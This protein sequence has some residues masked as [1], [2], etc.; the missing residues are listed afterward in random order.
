MNPFSDQTAKQVRHLRERNLIR[1][2]TA[3]LA[4]CNPPAP[5]G[6]GDDAAV[7]QTNQENLVITKDSLVFMKHFDEKA[8]PELV[9]A[10]L[11]KRNMSDLAAMGATPSHGVIA[12]LL[13]PTTSVKWLKK[14]YS[15]LNTTANKHAIS[16]VGGD[17]SS[18][19]E[20]LAFTLT[21]L[22]PGAAKA[23]TRKTANSGDTL[24]VTGS[25]GG[26]LLTKHLNFEPRVKEGNWLAQFEGV[27]SA[28]DVSDGLATDLLSLCPENCRVELDAEAIPITKDAKILAQESKA[29][30]IEQAMTD[31][32]DYELLFTLSGKESK[33]LLA[34]SS[35]PVRLSKI[36]HIK[37]SNGISM[38]SSNGK[39]KKIKPVGYE[40]FK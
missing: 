29:K 37:K 20:D 18:T 10:K 7:I 34:S 33:K 25:L 36:G 3:W 19:F 30:V 8:S 35:F 31:G 5:E 6:I 11:L 27:T 24:W 26:S 32:E 4:D 12:C 17:I 21:L 38:Q 23:L 40:H 28:I 2:I 16:I 22:G 1:K 9:G 15:G 14:F 13:P 39:L